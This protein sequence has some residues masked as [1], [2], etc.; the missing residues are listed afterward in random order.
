MQL[1]MPAVDWKVIYSTSHAAMP[2][3]A[4]HR[5]VASQTATHGAP[6]PSSLDCGMQTV[7]SQHGK[8]SQTASLAA[9]SAVVH[10]LHVYSLMLHVCL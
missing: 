5:H 3:A 6:P 4:M 1:A 8:H 9:Q 2:P 7:S 10:S